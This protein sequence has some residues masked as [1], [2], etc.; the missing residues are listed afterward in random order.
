MDESEDITVK[1][2]VVFAVRIVHPETFE[3][4]EQFLGFAE[5]AE[6]TGEALAK[7]AEVSLTAIGLDFQGMCGMAFDGAASMTGKSKGVRT[8]LRSKYPFARFLYCKGH[9]LNLVL[10]EAVRQGAS[11]KR[12]IDIIQSVTVYVKSSSRRLASF[13]EF[14]NGLEDYVETEKLKKLCSTR[15]VKRMPATRKFFATLARLLHLEAVVQ[16]GEFYRQCKAT[17]EEMDLEAPT[18]PRGLNISERRRIGGRIVPVTESDFETYF[19][20]QY[21]ALFQTALDEIEE[22]FHVDEAIVALE[23]V[24]IRYPETEASEVAIRTVSEVFTADVGAKALRREVKTVRLIRPDRDEWHVLD[25][26]QNFSLIPCCAWSYLTFVPVYV[27]S[28]YKLNHLYCRARLL[29]YEEAE[30]LPQKHMWSSSFQSR[31]NLSRAR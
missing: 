15:W 18:V 5:T 8:R 17:S 22:R 20:S 6:T 9:C 12:C 14:E 19:M 10:Q 31:S 27:C 1:E 11:M 29:C 21:R 2:Q 24:L 13:T 16:G 30:D 4:S 25:L 23:D 3:V 7:L 26:C 28:L